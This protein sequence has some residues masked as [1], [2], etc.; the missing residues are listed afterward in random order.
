M[1][2]TTPTR[3]QSSRDERPQI[4]ALRIYGKLMY[5]QMLN[6]LVILYAKSN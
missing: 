3:D 6:L 5:E 2:P 4:Q 1:D